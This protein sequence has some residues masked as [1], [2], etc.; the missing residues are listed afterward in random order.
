MDAHEL[1]EALA[2]STWCTIGSAKLTKI[3]FGEDAIT[4]VNLH[5]LARTN[6]DSVVVEDT[7][8]D[9]ARKG[10]DFELWI[11]SDSI[12]WLRYAIQAKKVN[13]SSGSYA[14][15]KHA[16]GGALQIDILERYASANRAAALYC[17]YNHSPSLQ[18]NCNFP[19][20]ATQLG[21]SVTPTSVV[22]AA[23]LKRGR[24]NARWMHSQTQTLPW[25]C[26]V[27]CPQLIA[28]SKYSGR[29]GWPDRKEFSHT[30]LPSALKTLRERRSAAALSDAPGLFSDN[31]QFRPRWVGVLDILDSRQYEA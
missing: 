26:L 9:E 2:H 14:K 10:C 31:L 7:R 16:V 18:W 19:P 4:S 6:P 3:A 24:R 17:F 30:E 28:G 22:R 15:L 27:R 25:R 21:C 8:V 20:A 5:A 23:L 11:G 1:F 29:D 13:P 12:G